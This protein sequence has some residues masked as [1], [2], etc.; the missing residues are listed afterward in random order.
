MLYKPEAKHQQF[1][2]KT[3][4]LLGPQLCLFAC[5]RQLDTIYICECGFDLC[6][7]N[8]AVSV[9][10]T[11]FVCLKMHLV[12]NNINT[13]CKQ[14]AQGA[15][16]AMPTTQ[17]TAKYPYLE[18]QYAKRGYI[19]LLANTRCK[20]RSALWCVHSDIWQTADLQ[21]GFVSS[22]QDGISQR[23][24]GGPLH[25]RRQPQHLRLTLAISCARAHQAQLALQDT[26]SYT[27]QSLSHSR[28][29]QH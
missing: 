19:L 6:H 3:A 17:H 1:I 13:G 27:P 14:G 8:A 15:N 26:Y 23:V 16:L 10:P 29:T 18:S 9:C 12:S 24:A 11:G 5:G 28:L 25:S 2:D 7:D 22:K 20:K 4:H 21:A